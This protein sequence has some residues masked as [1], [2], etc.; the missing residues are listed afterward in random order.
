VIKDPD[1][2]FKLLSKLTEN[3][4]N[5]RF[6]GCIKDKNLGKIEEFISKFVF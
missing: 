5:E 3:F 4:A 1:R 6:L 2:Y